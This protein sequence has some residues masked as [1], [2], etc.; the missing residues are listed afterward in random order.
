MRVMSPCLFDPLSR[1]LMMVQMSRTNRTLYYLGSL[2]RM[3]G[4]PRLARDDEPPFLVDYYYQLLVPRASMEFRSLSLGKTVSVPSRRGDLRRNAKKNSGRTDPGVRRCL[5]RGSLMLPVNSRNLLLL[6][7]RIG[8]QTSMKSRRNAC[9][10][11]R[12]SF[13]WGGTEIYRRVFLLSIL[14]LSQRE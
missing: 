9:C 6:W 2:G 11:P 10:N 5:R 4:R 7:V 13:K 3:R 1:I 12:K 8:W 14:Q